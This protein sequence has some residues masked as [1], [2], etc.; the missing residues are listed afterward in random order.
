MSEHEERDERNTFKDMSVLGWRI[1]WDLHRIVS[2]IVAIIYLVIGVWVFPPKSL[3]DLLA[4][5]LLTSIGLTFPLACIWFGDEMG[6]YTGSFFHP[7]TKVSPGIF[8]RLGGWILLLLPVLTGL[9]IGWI[10]YGQ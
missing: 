6:E 5:I 8:V 4:T 3:T 9:I 10:D 7:I 2:L 1:S